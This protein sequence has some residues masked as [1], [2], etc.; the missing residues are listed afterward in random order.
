[1]RI[2]LRYI[3][4]IGVFY[5][6]GVLMLIGALAIGYS[7]AEVREVVAAMGA[8]FGGTASFLTALGLFFGCDPIWWRVWGRK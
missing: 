4:V 8:T 7:L 2:D 3:I 6:P 5:A 1:M